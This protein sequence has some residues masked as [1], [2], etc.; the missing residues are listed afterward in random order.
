M[1]YFKFLLSLILTLG[2][3]YGLNTK[4]GSIPPIG[5]F[6]NPYSGVWQNETDEIIDGSVIISGLKDKVIVHYDAQLIPHLFAQNESDLYKAQGYITA[7]HRL[8]QMEF[9]T[10]AAA[11]RLSEILGER[12]L[13]YDRQER[14]RGMTYGAEQSLKDMLADSITGSL[15]QDFADGVNSYINTLSPD[16]YPVEYKLLDYA[17]EPWTVNKT[18]NLLMYMTKMLAGGDDDLEYTNILRSLVKNVSIYC[19][20]IFIPTMTL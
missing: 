2:I 4:F 1:K 3:F 9:Q 15:I 11:G 19:F 8:W 16:D 20:Q 12:A 17:P 6:L 5:K 13:N 7:K 18:A 14:R 10:Y